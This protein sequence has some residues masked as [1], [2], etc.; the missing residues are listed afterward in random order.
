MADDLS[1]AIPM[2]KALFAGGVRGLDVTLRTL[3]PL[4]TIRAITNKVSEAI[5]DAGTVLNA[6]QIDDVMLGRGS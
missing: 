5:V 4:D 3:V 6:Q 1:H 2:A